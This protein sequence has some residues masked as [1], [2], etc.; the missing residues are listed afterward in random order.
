MKSTTQE[1]EITVPNIG[2]KFVDLYIDNKKGTC[3]IFEFKFYSK[4]KAEQHPN[5]LQEKIDKAKVFLNWV[6]KTKPLQKELS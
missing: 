5:I 4:N 2:K 1:L 3:Y 6:Q